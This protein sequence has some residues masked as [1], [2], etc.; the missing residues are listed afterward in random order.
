LPNCPND[1]GN[2]RLFEAKKLADELGGIAAARKALD[3]LEKLK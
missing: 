3:A 2:A 1:G